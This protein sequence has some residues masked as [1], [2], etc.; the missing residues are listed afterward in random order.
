MSDALIDV[1]VNL[2]Q[3]P[4]RRTEGDAPAALAAKLKRHGVTEAWA[5]SF[6]GLFFADL[7]EVNAQLAA[8]CRAQTDVRLIPF[9]EINP[10]LPD[11]EA[12]LHRCTDTHRMPGI[13]LH[14]NYHG[15]TLDHPQF[16]R[17]FA[18]AAERQLIVAIAASMEDARM[19]HP[20]LQAPAANLSPLAQLVERTPR[21]RLLLLN[22]L[23]T[24]RGDPLHRLLNAGEA[25]VEIA[26]LEGMGGIEKLLADVPLERVLFGS[27]AP[28][29]YFE[30]AALKLQESPL[31]ASQRLA[32]TQEN[33]RRLLPSA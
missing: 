11:W 24:F 32:I 1:N 26:M 18:V 12:E 7:A 14:P 3:W 22:A 4:T 20:L 23:Q 2:G 5:G 33:A 29:F 9:G 30:A 13:R 19:M 8:D 17:L 31:S 21:S 10:L 25:Y 28:S 15:Y 6:D 27:H 16:A